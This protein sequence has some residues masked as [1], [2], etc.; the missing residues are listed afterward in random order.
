M[1]N[2]HIRFYQKTKLVPNIQ[3]E[4]L[5]E[6]IGIDCMIAH[7]DSI[8]GL[9]LLLELLPVLL[10]LGSAHRTSHGGHHVLVSN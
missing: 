7:L 6:E 2:N 9:T 5:E 1:K 10:P 8:T 3:Q 4:L